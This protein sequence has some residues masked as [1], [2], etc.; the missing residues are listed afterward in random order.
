MM[1][2]QRIYENDPTL[3][4]VDLSYTNDHDAKVIASVLQSNTTIQQV[5]MVSNNTISMLGYT[6]LLESFQHNT[7]ITELVLSCTGID[8]DKIQVLAGLLIQPNKSSIQ[9][10]NLSYNRTMGID[11]CIQLLTSLVQNTI[12]TTLWLNYTV[13]PTNDT[14]IPSNS[15]MDT[16]KVKQF[17][18]VLGQLI[19]HNTSLRSINLRGNHLGDGILTELTPTLLLTRPTI[20]LQELYLDDNCI[21][22][23]GGI[24]IAKLLQYN[25]PFR[26]LSISKNHM[27]DTAAIA[28]AQSLRYNTT[29]QVLNLTE[30]HFTTTIGIRTILQSLEYNTRLKELYIFG[31]KVAVGSASATNHTMTTTTTNNNN[32][33]YIHMIGPRP[34]MIPRLFHQ[35]LQYNDTIH[36]IDCSIELSH[37]IHSCNIVP[38]L[39]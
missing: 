29:C 17:S 5:N 13:C 15:T 21:G 2:S 33:N 20:T 9:Q 7:S 25:I 11:A 28:I 4:C 6:V 19:Q 35:L 10:L 39:K 31:R 26:T 3:Q 37:R 24:A 16:T 12:V 8:Y 18:Q 23:D 32:N 38:T 27:D 34:N 30:N 22:N 1:M 14:I 36:T